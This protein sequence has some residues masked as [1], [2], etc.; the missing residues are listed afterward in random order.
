MNHAEVF[1]QLYVDL[2]THF[3]KRLQ[4]EQ[5][6]YAINKAIE[7]NNSLI[8]QASTGAGKSYASLIPAICSGKRIVYATATNALSDQL[9]TK[10]LPLLSYIFNEYYDIPFTFTSLK[11]IGNYA[12]K[13]EINHETPV[14]IV[15]IVED[16]AFDG[17]IPAQTKEWKK[18][19]IGSDDCSGEACK[20]FSSCKY[21]QARAQAQKATVTV[22]NHSILVYDSLVRQL[23]DGTKSLLGDFDVL[24]I[25]EAHELENS[26]TSAYEDKISYRGLIAL[27]NKVSDVATKGYFSSK[28]KVEL[29]SLMNSK[30]WFFDIFT[31]RK[32]STTLRIKN[33]SDKEKNVVNTLV[34]TLSDLSFVLVNDYTL[35]SDRGEKQYCI[36]LNKII[37]RV[38]KIKT[39]LSFDVDFVYQLEYDSYYRTYTIKR[40]PLKIDEY[41]E[42]I[43]SDKSVIFMSA[44]LFLKNNTSFIRSRLGIDDLTNDLDVGTPFNLDRQ[45]AFYVASDLPSPKTDTEKF[46]KNSYKRIKDL[47]SLSKGRALVL[48]PSVKTMHEAYDYLLASN[49]PFEIRHQK[50]EQHSIKDLSKWFKENINGVLLGTDSF[51]TGVSFEGETCSLVII[52]K[53]PFVSP[54]DP[55]HEARGEV[56][57]NSF[58]DYFVPLMLMKTKQWMGR[59]IRTPEDQGIIAVLDSRLTQSSWWNNMYKHHIKYKGAE[60]VFDLVKLK[61][62]FFDHI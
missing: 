7:S 22:T 53:L 20:F 48:F 30:D 47:L 25:D 29:N 44:T 28:V 14:N 60:E 41:C 4:Q 11:G 18:L 43:Y 12:C 45:C 55:L 57:E 32:D 15:D 61:E 50:M 26:I 8:L 33:L 6:A 27:A 24:I 35:A 40:N 37:R 31:K 59:L 36:E 38:N 51:G 34:E 13:A 58:N 16:I 19:S 10:D 52:H 46:N 54:G 23:T 39:I 49:L 9:M 2:P 42:Q 21:Q 5:A 62:L 56:V 3:Q 1:S 17:L